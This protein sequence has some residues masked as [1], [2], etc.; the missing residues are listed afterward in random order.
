MAIFFS[1]TDDAIIVLFSSQGHTLFQT[2]DNREHLAMM[3][4]ILAEPVPM[5]M[6]RKS[7]TKYFNSQQK[8]IWDKNSAEARYTNQ[9][10]RPLNKYYMKYER[11]T[12]K[13]MGEMDMLDLV[14]RMLEYDPQTRITLR[15]CL[16]HEFFESMTRFSNEDHERLI[17]AT[18]N[19]VLRLQI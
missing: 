1:G 18:S 5:H 13:G 17:E 19:H 10:C 9:N 11:H 3:E 14:A 8:L 16:R 4:K 7:R 15:E 12:A 2:H 6:V